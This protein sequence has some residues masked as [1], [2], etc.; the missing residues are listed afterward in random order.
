MNKKTYKA[1]LKHRRFYSQS[2]VGKVKMEDLFK[3]LCPSTLASEQNL[4]PDRTS[5][6]RKKITP[7]RFSPESY[8]VVK[9]CLI[10]LFIF[11]NLSYYYFCFF[12]SFIILR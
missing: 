8:K 6:I 5:N 1:I 7:D 11:Y 9:D 12:I 10:T 2:E 4:T 3:T